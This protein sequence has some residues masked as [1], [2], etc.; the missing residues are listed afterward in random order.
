MQMEYAGGV[1]RWQGHKIWSRH[2]GERHKIRGTLH[3][4]LQYL[5][6]PEGGHTTLSCGAV[7][8]NAQYN[9]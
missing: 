5:V 3:K 8:K 2:R 1:C 4:G 9:V 7:G 6:N